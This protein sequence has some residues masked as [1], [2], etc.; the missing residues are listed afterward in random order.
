MPRVVITQDFKY[1]SVVLSLLKL[2]LWCKFGFHI[3][4]IMASGHGIMIEYPM[5]LYYSYSTSL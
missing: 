1:C 5:H 3:I 4:N 2:E